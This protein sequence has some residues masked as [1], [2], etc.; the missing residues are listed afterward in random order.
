M[1]KYMRFWNL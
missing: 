1:V